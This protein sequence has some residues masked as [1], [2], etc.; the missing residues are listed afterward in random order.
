M[1]CLLAEGHFHQLGLVCTIC[2]YARCYAFLTL[3]TTNE[4]LLSCLPGPFNL[5]D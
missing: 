5:E 4:L 2:H 1:L 3:L